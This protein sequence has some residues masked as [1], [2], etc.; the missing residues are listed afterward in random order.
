M[1]FALI[2][3]ALSGYKCLEE[4]LRQNADVAGIFTL[5]DEI[6]A[7]VSGFVPFDVIA[8]RNGIPIF[9]VKKISDPESVAQIRALQPDVIFV[10]GFSQLISKE[11]LAIPRRGCIGMHPTLLPANRGRAPIPWTIING[12]RKSGATMF[13]LD[14][15]ADSGPIIGQVQFAVSKGETAGSLYGKA[16]KAFVKLMRRNLP[17]IMKGAEKRIPQD[18]KKASYWPKRTP[19]DGLIDWS[20]PA[21]QAWALV[22]A[23]THP[24]PGAFTFL[25]GKKMLIWEARPAKKSAGRLKRGEIFGLAK[26]GFFVSAGGG[27]LLVKKA[28]LEGAPETDA[29]KFFKDNKLKIGELLG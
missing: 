2:S 12:L 17:L 24:Y 18:A 19:E 21:V 23:V 13:F 20:K 3:A 5:K 10:I 7:D 8:A 6:A 14:E 9:K 16:V 29:V 1:K 22:R 28:Q 15:G 25:G 4:M 26:N 11:I 27:A